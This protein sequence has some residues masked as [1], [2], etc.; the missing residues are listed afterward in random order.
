MGNIQLYLKANE[1]IFINGAV[2]KVDRKVSFELLNDVTFLLESNVIQKEEADTAMKQ[3]Y[4]V[5]QLMLMH[6]ADIDQP[7]T[8]FKAMVNG[9]L[10]TLETPELIKGVKDV[11]VEVSTGKY[12]A[13]LKIVRNL[14]AIEAEILNPG[15]TPVNE[16]STNQSNALNKARAIAGG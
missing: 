2:L 15:S 10:A 3:L 8:M 5:V 1:K 14:I 13:A 9:L 7:M 12:F 11:D 4:F 16:L 6:P